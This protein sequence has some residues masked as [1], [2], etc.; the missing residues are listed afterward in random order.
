M[1]AKITSPD[2]IQRPLFYNEHKVRKGDAKMLYASGFPFNM[3][4]LKIID[5]LDY[6]EHILK[7]SSSKNKALHITLNFSNDDQ[8]YPDKLIE[9]AGK[10]MDQI[11]FGAQP[12]LIYQH[13]DADHPHIHIVTITIQ[14]DGKRINTHMI[15]ADK[16]EKARR[17]IETSYGLTEVDKSTREKAFKFQPIIHLT[18]TSEI[19]S[20]ITNILGHVLKEYLFGSLEEFN[21]ILKQYNL[22]ADRGEKD[23]RV[24][25]H[26][27]LL[28][29]VIDE[30]GKFI[31]DPIKASLFYNNP[32][33]ATLESKF[34]PPTSPTRAKKKTH[35]QDTIDSYFQ[36][37]QVSISDLVEDLKQKDIYTILRLSADGFLYGITYVD[38]LNK[39]VFNGSALGKQYAAKAIQD[40]I[41][42]INPLGIA[43][44]LNAIPDINKTIRSREIEK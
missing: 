16:S 32:T 3:Q 12:Y 11:G 22:I 10:Y 8:L 31:G 33:L 38:N 15:G 36:K 25:Q 19:K 30:K 20:A 17:N 6:F 42:N 23:S 2:N 37:K 29:R 1:I 28:Y 13:F 44:F 26:E 9:I 40:R 27:G 41:K 24:Y 34:C 14:A 4:Q 39:S 35:L 18:K 5:K 7:Q 21:A 43:D